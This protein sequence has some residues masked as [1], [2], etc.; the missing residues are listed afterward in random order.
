MRFCIILGAMKA[1]TTSLF[2]YLAQHPEISPCKEKEPSFFVHHYS[3]GLEYYLKLWP[4]EDIETKVLLEASVNYT[5]CFSFPQ[6]SENLLDFTQKYDVSMK[7]IYVMRN[8]IDRLVS[9]YTYS[10]ARWTSDS[11]QQRIE[12]GHIIDVSRY[13]HQLDQYYSRFDPDHFLLLDFDD[14]I[15]KPDEVLKK[16]C[17]HLHIDAGFR[18]SDL[19]Q[20]YNKSEGTVITRPIEKVYKQYPVVKSFAGLFSKSFKGHLSKLVFRKRITRKFKLSED[21]RR[22]VYGHLKDDMKVLK[23]K[24]GV[25]VEKWGF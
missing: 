7:Y 15:R 16:V 18:F 9:Q 11:L 14:L 21:K 24:Y 25:N 17:E 5:K 3:K 2:H 20:V 1:G 10:F 4:A 13:A 22:Y 6:A 23:E 19:E 12:H 8:P